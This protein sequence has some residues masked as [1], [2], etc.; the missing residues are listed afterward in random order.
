MSSILHIYRT[1]LFSKFPRDRSVLFL[2]SNP[3]KLSDMIDLNYLVTCL[4]ISSKKIKL[5]GIYVFTGTLESTPC[6]RILLR[7]KIKYVR[8]FINCMKILTLPINKFYLNIYKNNIFTYISLYMC[9]VYINIYI[10]HEHVH[11]LEV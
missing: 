1:Q 8:P 4:E 11:F 9:I 3:Q 10:Q 6:S 7:V 2:R 5:I